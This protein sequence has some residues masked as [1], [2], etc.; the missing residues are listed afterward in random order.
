MANQ[1]IKVRVKEF[2][3]RIG[4]SQRELAEKLGIKPETVYKWS[5]GASAPTHQVSY[6]LKKM[7]ITDYELFGEEFPPPV[8]SAGEMNELVNEAL[9][10]IVGN[11]GKI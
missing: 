2:A 7:G 5:T 3:A 4:I 6:L 10:R 1:K 8:K 9:R 11:I